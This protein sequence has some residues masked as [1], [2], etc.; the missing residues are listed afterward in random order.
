MMPD[1]GNVS[2][3]TLEQ[4]LEELD[5]ADQM[6]A[7]SV[8][9][10]KDVRKRAVAAGIHI[11]A[12]DQARKVA[13]QS[14]DKREEHDRNFRQYMW[15][16]GKPIGFQADWVGGVGARATNGED[17]NELQRRQVSDAGHTAGIDGRDRSSNPWT[18][19]T[20]MAA[21]WDT[22]WLSGQTELA[23][24]MAPPD[25]PKKRGRPPGSRNRPRGVP[26]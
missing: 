19:S 18:P 26:P 25:A 21:I 2:Q 17:I 3:A 14:G 20:D 13:K 4:F 23:E 11:K 6:V 24:R 8:G 10:R 5:N 22:G 15:M 1:G 7:E 12:L 9:N 16:M